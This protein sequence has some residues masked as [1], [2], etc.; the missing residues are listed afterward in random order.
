MPNAIPARPKTI[1]VLKL[2]ADALISVPPFPFIAQRACAVP[3]LSVKPTAAGTRARTPRPP[4]QSI[5]S[6]TRLAT[7]KRGG[8]PP[9][10]A[11]PPTVGPTLVAKAIHPC[12]PVSSGGQALAL[13][14]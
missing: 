13:L 1:A 9:K 7:P 8:P 4:R 12:A 11:R 5:R 2:S 10:S 3:R 14:V 6:P